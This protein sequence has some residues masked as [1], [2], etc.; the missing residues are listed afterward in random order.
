MI[1]ALDAAVERMAN[2]A[3]SKPHMPF[4]AWSDLVKHELK[5]MH[6]AGRR[7]AYLDG[8]I[9]ARDVEYPYTVHDLIRGAD[10]RLV[11]EA[12][13]RAKEALATPTETKPTPHREAD[14]PKFTTRGYRCDDCLFE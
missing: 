1:D 7:D 6:E 13:R 8:L 10:P 11:A 12:T 4:H 2:L 14:C 3:N 9:A 5:A